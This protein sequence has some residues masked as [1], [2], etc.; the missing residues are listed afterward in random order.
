MAGRRRAPLRGG[1]GWHS[2]STPTAGLRERGNDTNTSTGR[3][4]R[5]N[6]ATQHNTPRET[7]TGRNVTQVVP[8]PLPMHC[9]WFAFVCFLIGSH[10]P[11]SNASLLGG[12]ARIL[13]KGGGCA[14]RAGRCP[15][16]GWQQGQQGHDQPTARGTV[17]VVR[18]CEIRVRGAGGWDRSGCAKGA[19]RSANIQGEEQHRHME[20][21]SHTRRDK[22]EHS[23]QG[24]GVQQGRRGN[25]D[26][27]P[28]WR[29]WESVRM[30]GSDNKGDGQPAPW[31]LGARATPAQP[32]S[33]GGCLPQPRWAV[34]ATGAGAHQGQTSRE[35]E[36]D[37]WW[38]A[39]T[40]RGGTGHLGLT[41]T[42][43]QQV[44]DGLWTKAR[45]RQ[46]QSNNPGNNQHNQ[47]GRP[48]QIP[49]PNP[50]PPP[51]APKVFEPVFHQIEILG[52]IVGAG[53]PTDVSILKILRI[54]WRI[55]KWVKNTRKK[56]DPPT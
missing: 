40:A 14:P 26:R 13:H 50:P 41:H 34:C 3:S 39:R 25:Q 12:G 43:T 42:E 45:G 18:G 44:M 24:G 47:V 5:Q 2:P 16:Q 36:R 7:A 29:G 9:L 46:K 38:M 49:D 10:T 35:G 27:E 28:E 30:R 22:G 52:E 4:G 1:G 55:H 15:P 53:R 8:P 37:I 6:A 33:G 56:I 32:A 20:R 19:P 17:N 23:R 54:W 31:L 51:R 48:V 11:S 21:G